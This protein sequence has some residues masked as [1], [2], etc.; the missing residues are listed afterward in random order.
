ML[1]IGVVVAVI[2]ILMVMRWWADGEYEAS[3]AFL[4]ASVFGLL[5]MGLFAART[6]VQ[7]LLAFIPLTVAGGYAYWSYRDGGVR[8]YMKKKCKDYVQAIAFD[9]TNTAAREHYA[10][11]LYNLGKLDQAIDE[12]QVAVDM[13]AGME[14][15]YTLNQWTKERYRRDSTYP[16]CIWCNTENLTNSRRCSRCGCELP[17]QSPLS[18]WLTSGPNSGARLLLI[19]SAGIA[20]ITIS[21]I[22]LPLKFA[23]IPFGFCLLAL[24]GWSLIASAKGC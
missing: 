14:T 8:A 2:F 22:V 9:P 7:F 21:L 23:F 24:I 17:Y 5:F 19:I 16:I 10:R 6:W 15:Q 18:R 13:G 1:L 4:L 3:E 12:I 11:T 20:L